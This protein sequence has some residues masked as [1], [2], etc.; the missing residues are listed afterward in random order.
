MLEAA[1]RSAV[2]GDLFRIYTIAQRE[3]AAFKWNTIPE[4]VSLAGEEFF[5]PV[6]MTSLYE[7]GFQR[8]KAGGEWTT[9]LPGEVRSTLRQRVR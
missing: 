9:R 5:D 7:V 6:L 3:N 4:G 8:G 2:L 1:G